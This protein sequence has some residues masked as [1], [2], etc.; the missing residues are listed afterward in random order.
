VAFYLGPGGGVKC[1]PNI[2]IAFDTVYA[3]SL[4]RNKRTHNGEVVALMCRLRN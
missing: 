2:E 3:C 1:I 4:R